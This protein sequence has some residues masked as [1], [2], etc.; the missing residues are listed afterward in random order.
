[1]RNWWIRGAVATAVLALVACG[2]GGDGGDPLFGDGDGGGG[3]PV[4]D[5]SNGVP[6]QRSMSLAVETYNLDWSF[7][8]ATTQVSVRVTDTAGNP[9]PAG[10]VVQFS[11]EG[12]QILTSCALTGVGGG[13]DPEISECSVTFATQNV[14]PADGA[15][16][17]VAWMEG[18]EAFIDANGNGRYDAG[19]PFFDQGRV[20][21]DDNHTGAYET[22][23][24]ELNIGAAAGGAGLGSQACGPKLGSVASD[25]GFGPF[26]TPLSVDNSC[27]GAWGRTLVRADV[28]LPLSDPRGLN[29]VYSGG[30]L[31]VFTDYGAPGRDSADVAA[32]AGTTLVAVGQ[33]TGCT[34]AFSPATVP[35]N[36][37]GPTEHRL[38]ATGVSCAGASFAVRLTY[39]A[40]QRLVPVTL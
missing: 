23:G 5:V 17:I 21:R 11:T 30:F 13:G 15:V 19:E 16:A 40:Y 7:D 14:R 10:T 26:S 4:S 24:D 29:G 36:G 3:G 18:Q 35:S 8:G 37:V 33:P 34:V 2:G 6:S 38:L 20:F 1:M 27:D 22:I 12:G 28:V 25:F 39:G 9:V 32:P 31:E